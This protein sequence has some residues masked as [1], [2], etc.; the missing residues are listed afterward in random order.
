M[1]ESSPL[2]VFVDGAIMKPQLGGI[3]T[4]ISELT[5]A[6][7]RRADVEVC[8]ATSTTVGLVRESDL[9]VIELPASVR[10]FTRR[11]AWRERRLRALVRSWNASV[12]LAPTVELPVRRLPVPAIMVVHDLGPMQ[13]PELY[14]RL[15]WLRFAAG[16]PLACRRADHVVCVSQA[17]FAALRKTFPS[18]VAA[19]TVIGEAG[20]VMPVRQREPS[21][22]PY[23]FS[24]GTLMTHKNVETLVKAMD[25]PLLR[26]VDLIVAGPTDDHQR[27][28]FARWRNATSTAAR[29]RHVGYVDTERLSDLYAG[30]AVV[31]LPSLYEGFGLTLLEAMRSGAPAVASSIPAHREVGGDGAIYVEKSLSADAWAEA[32]AGVIDDP[33]RADA[34]S[35]RAQLRAGAITW[36]A[37]AEQMVTLA[38]DV[39]SER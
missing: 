2:R 26:C 10:Q 24:V 13:A 36:E 9:E 22:P 33:P 34:L 4:Y 11:F 18:C 21:A 28:L 30:A 29:V 39:V 6:L 23:I 8:I 17:T 5:N 31:A 16:V 38:R 27:T 19:C 14:G 32:L 35:R 25:N 37:I 7:A 20:R 15:R 12:L 1:S 3:A